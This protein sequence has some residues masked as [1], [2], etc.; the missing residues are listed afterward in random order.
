MITLEPENIS[1]VLNT[2]P[3]G[4]YWNNIEGKLQGCNK[5]FLEMA[6]FDSSEE[7]IGKTFSDITWHDDD[8]TVFT[9][10][11]IDQFLALEEKLLNSNESTLSSVVKKDATK[12][13]GQIWLK[14]QQYKLDLEGELTGVLTICRD[15][16]ETEKNIQQMKMANMRA[17]ASA[18]EL[19]EYIENVQQ[20]QFETMK[21][22]IKAEEA[23]QAKSE[24]LANM[25][26]ELRTP[27]N[28]VL[29]MCELLL[30]STLN[31]KQKENAEI[32]YKSGND[33]LSILND[34]LDISKIE[35][36]ELELE[37][38][39]FHVS[40]AIREIHQLFLP[41]AHDSGLEIN[42]EQGD[43]IPPTIIG[44][45]GKVQQIFRNLISNALKFTERGS[46][47]ILV[48]VIEEE[49]APY[50]YM[51]VKDTGAGI[52]FDKLEAI[53]EKFTQANTSVTRK[54]GGTGLGLAI[55]QHLSYAMGGTIGVDSV[56]NEGSTFWFTIPLEVSEDDMKAVNLYEQS[57]DVSNL[58]LPT[59]INILVV[60]DHP[61]N[62][63]FANKLLTK[64]GFANIEM[65]EN[66]KEALEKI[67]KNNYDIVLMDCQMPEIDGYKATT[68]LREKEEQA[69]SARLPVIALTA[70]AMLGDREKCLKS[71]MDDYLSKPI[72]AEKLTAL[73]KK[74]IGYSEDSYRADKIKVGTQKIDENP[75]DMEHLEA[76]TDGD[77]EE[78]KELYNMF[79][80]H[81]DNSVTILETKCGSDENEA[82]RKEA[83]KIKGS[84]ANLGANDLSEICKTAEEKFEETEK[85]KRILLAKIQEKMGKVK[86]FFE[87]RGH[88]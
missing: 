11:E 6:R 74:W 48:N 50:L 35:A 23:S 7:V 79:I 39:P 28:G 81:A 15:I 71:G 54:F 13:L 4:I 22:K 29:G 67:A 20:A 38:V 45:L 63:I 27:M 68:M 8:E 84:A 53:F 46:V 70:N 9:K 37:F 55:S 5:S 61:V 17:E 2:L 40:T 30:N 76:F 62:R 16:T 57:S 3:H 12:N 80:E 49:G 42:V 24:F 32:I 41:R 83:H 60:D 59:H 58:S 72:K 33:L 73:L 77:H 88:E 36:G 26:H 31:G 47:T 65:A 14:I 82:W 21:A 43:N 66:G 56:E 51:A 78:E 69:N 19:N 75:V 10:K 44:D 64:L 25:S 52:P 18:I 34:I 87:R 85:N 1:I 86:I